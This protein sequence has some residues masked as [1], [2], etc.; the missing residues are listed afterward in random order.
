MLIEFSTSIVEK[1]WIVGALD[2]WIVDVAKKFVNCWIVGDWWIVFGPWDCLLLFWFIVLL[3]NLRFKC[4]SLGCYFRLLF[5]ELFLFWTILVTLSVFGGPAFVCIILLLLNC[6]NVK[7]IDFCLSRVLEKISGF[8]D[9]CMSVRFEIIFTL[10]S[11]LRYFVSILRI[12]LFIA[13]LLLL[14]LEIWFDFD[15]SWC[16]FSKL[17]IETLLL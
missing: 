16:I 7:S 17:E 2:N 11:F 10:T 5:I 3:W 9:Y 8:E 15:T 1:F 4:L 14:H 12:E 13:E 6:G